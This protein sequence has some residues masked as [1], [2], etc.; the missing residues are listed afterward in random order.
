MKHTHDTADKSNLRMALDAMKVS[1]ELVVIIVILKSAANPMQ[2]EDPYLGTEKKI[3]RFEP[4]KI[5]NH[6]C[7]AAGIKCEVI[8]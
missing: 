4:L 8:K 3:L 6:S 1:V 5:I 7:L 2:L